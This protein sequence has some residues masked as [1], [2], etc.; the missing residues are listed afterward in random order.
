VAKIYFNFNRQLEVCAEQI[1]ILFWFLVETYPCKV[2]SL[3]PVGMN[4]RTDTMT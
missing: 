4:S 1:N 2:T 3:Q